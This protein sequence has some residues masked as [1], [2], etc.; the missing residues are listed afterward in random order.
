MTTRIL[1]PEEYGRLAGTEAAALVPQLTDA[2]RVVVV[3]RDGEILGCHVL[4]IVLHAEGLWIHPDHR[5]RSS[6]GRR[7]WT[8][9]QQTVRDSFGVAWFMTGCANADV[10]QL[11]AHVGAVKLVDHYMVPVGGSPCQP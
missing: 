5:K 9:V 1:P 10:A 4:Q 11:L 8:A 3:E 6:V 2:A 7:L